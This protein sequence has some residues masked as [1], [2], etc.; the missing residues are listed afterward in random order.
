MGLAGSRA[1]PSVSPSVHPPRGAPHTKSRDALVARVVSTRR[2]SLRLEK[3]REQLWAAR[4]GG[5]VASG[6]PLRISMILGGCRMT[7]WR[8]GRVGA[9]RRCWRSAVRSWVALGTRSREAGEE[10][11]EGRWRPSRQGLVSFCNK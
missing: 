9:P 10:E 5:P 7:A 6:M 8:A 1:A 2:S 4:F 3:R 11:A